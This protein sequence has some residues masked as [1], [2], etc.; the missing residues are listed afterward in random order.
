MRPVA[1][2]LV[3]ARLF[4]PRVGD[5]T[6]LGFEARVARD[7]N[8]D[9]RQAQIGQVAAAS[10]FSRDRKLS[11]FDECA[12]ALG[13]EEREG[14]GHGD[15]DGD[16]AEKGGGLFQAAPPP[17]PPPPPSDM[18]LPF[19][20]ENYPNDF[21]EDANALD[22]MGRMADSFSV[23]DVQTEMSE[24]GAPV[25]PLLPTLT[26]RC[27]RQDR[28]VFASKLRFPEREFFFAGRQSQSGIS[29]LARKLRLASSV[30]FSLALRIMTQNMSIRRMREIKNRYGLSA[31]D[32]QLIRERINAR[33]G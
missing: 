32:V 28:S 25:S 1:R 21:A 20:F 15:G 8:G 24:V 23:A 5:L 11:V 22:A 7:A 33:S 27:T 6:R 26:A 10:A 13:E 31:E 19:L 9:I 3:E 16:G 2:C 4:G 18:L 29:L 17:P 14:H 30:D 12:T